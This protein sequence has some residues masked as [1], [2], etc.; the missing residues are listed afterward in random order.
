MKVWLHSKDCCL[1]GGPCGCGAIKI[2]QPVN[3]LH[4]D[5][6][7]RAEQVRALVESGMLSPEKGQLL[8]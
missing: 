2:D 8:L 5:P 3:V 1:M 6:K 4:R 7:V